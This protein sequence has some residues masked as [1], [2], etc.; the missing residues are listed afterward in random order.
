HADLGAEHARGVPLARRVLDEPGITGTEHVLRAIAQAD[1]ELA[2]ENDRKLPAGG[3]VPVQ[4][5]AGRPFSERDLAR[6]ETFQ[7]VGLRLEIDL[8]DVGLL[9]GARGQPECPHHG[10]LARSTNKLDEIGM[11]AQIGLATSARPPG[12]AKNE[13]KRCGGSRL[14]GYSDSRIGSCSCSANDLACC[15]GCRVMPS[16]ESGKVLASPG[17]LAGLTNALWA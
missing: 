8:L 13:N 12:T 17:L 9:I 3:R 15:G 16:R 1:L 10:L 2:R 5:L 14:A 4:E 7:P 11:L 6:G